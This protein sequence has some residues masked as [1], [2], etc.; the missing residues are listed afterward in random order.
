LGEN[1]SARQW[2][3]AATILVAVEGLAVALWLIPASVHIV[4]WPASGPDRVALFGSRA[5]MFGLG[6]A[7]AV[8]A[9]ALIAWGRRAGN[10]AWV[11][12][13][14]A[15]FALLWLWVVPYLPWLPDRFPLLLVL[16]GPVRWI[17]AAIAVIAAAGIDQR[18]QHA[19]GEE[20]G[21]PG[22]WSIFA[23]SLAIYIVFGLYSSRTVGPGGDEPHYLIIAQSLLADGD[24]Q[25]ENNHQLGEYR[26]FFRGDLR[27]D[28]L[29][30]GVNGQIYSIHAPGLAAL[31]LPAYAVAGYAGAVVFMCLLAALTSLAVFD[32]A[33]ALA[34]RQAAFLTWLAV[35]LT[36]PFVPYSWLIFPEIAGALVLAWAALW[37]QQ[38][39]EERAAVWIW[40]G[41]ALGFLPW[42]HTKF[43]VFLAVFGAALFLRI[44]KRPK[45]ALLFSAPIIAIVGTWLY[46]FYAIYGKVNPGAPYGNYANQHILLENIPRGILGLM[47]DQK[48]GLLFYSPIYLFAT[49]GCWIMLRR[50][51]LRLLGLTSLLATGVFVGGATELYMWWGGNSAPARYLVPLLPC[52]APM[53]ALGITAATS[54]WARTL[55]GVWLSVSLALA[56][57]GVGWPDRFLIFSEPHGRARLLETIQGASPLALSLPTFT[58][59]DWQGALLDL[60]PWV[61]AALVGL[62]AIVLIARWRE[63]TPLWLG[64][65]GATVALVAASVMVGRASPAV[66]DDTARRG[67]LDVMWRYDPARLRALDYD[68]LQRLDAGQL[69]RLSTLVIRQPSGNDDEPRGMA[70][71]G[72]FTLPEGAYEAR[73]WFAS[74]RPPNGEIVISS[75]PQA[76]FGRL[77]GSLQNPAIVPFALPTTIRRVSI[78]VADATL[79]AAVSRI[80]VAPAVIIPSPERENIPV[81]AIESIADRPGAFILYV[82][83]STYPEGGVFWTRD[84]EQA[85]I[86]IAPAGASRLRLILHLGPMSGNVLVSVAGAEFPVNVKASDVTV[87]ETDLPKGLRLVPVTIQSPARFRPVEVDPASTDTRRLGCQVRVGLL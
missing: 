26:A 87:F 56:I 57:V 80:E 24:I 32:L 76:V 59:L 36:V 16:A 15:P 60:M 1:A 25:I 8:V 31:L 40:R 61:A 11:A 67:A 17:V 78:G 52:L 19:I 46:F 10:I 49:A 37:V 68:G 79:A 3:H 72:P 75:S 29:Q 18:V 5:A 54:A 38:P 51:D 33:A 9:F 45:L 50:R 41:I 58:E 13:V 71:A 84:T 65:I 63:T 62:G 21:L 73:V 85:A 28:F 47:V 66:R 55:L 39:L 14:A 7:G 23:L 12:A 20:R 43:S 30:R 69:L 42:L 22:R 81:R 53:V 35:C 86:M 34:G 82:D 27:P 77:S 70:S 48:F 6:A 2:R 83:E 4:G 44:W 74:A 64:T